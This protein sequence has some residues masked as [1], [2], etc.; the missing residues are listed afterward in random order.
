ML[1]LDG[2]PKFPSNNDCICHIKKHA[3]LNNTWQPQNCITCSFQ[4]TNISFELQIHNIIP[5]I[6]NKWFPTV[7][8]A[9]RTLTPQL[10]HT[11]CVPKQLL[12]P[13]S[14]EFPTK[15]HNFNRHS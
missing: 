10:G 11:T 7:L 8:L 5:I 14:N 15:R 9:I 12:Q 4:T 1:I 3:M 2:D 6:G 13:L